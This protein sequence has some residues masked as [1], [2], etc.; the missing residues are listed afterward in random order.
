MKWALSGA[1]NIWPWVKMS[2]LL[3]AVEGAVGA[4]DVLVA[5]R[6]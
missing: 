3:S 2:F 4:A 5:D 6:A 1:H